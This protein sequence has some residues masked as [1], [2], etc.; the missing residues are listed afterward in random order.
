M[1]IVELVLAAIIQ[2]RYTKRKDIKER[3]KEKKIKK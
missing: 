3:E 2:N 1:S